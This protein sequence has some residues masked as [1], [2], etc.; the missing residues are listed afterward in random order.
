M[1]MLIRRFMP[2]LTATAGAFL[3]TAFLSSA[4][5]QADVTYEYIV[6]KHG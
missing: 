3:A 5:A 2:G 4:F 1:P 6:P